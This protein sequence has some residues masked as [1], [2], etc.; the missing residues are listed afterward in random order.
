MEDQNKKIKVLVISDHIASLSGVALETRN[1]IDGLVKTGRYKF[2]CLG[3][4]IKH[5]QYNPQKFQEYGDDVVVYPVDGYGDQ[6]TYRTLLRME[7]PDIVWMI[8]DPRFYVHLW[9]MA[10]EIRPNLPIVY[11]HVWDNKPTPF[12][13][14]SYYDSNDV[15]CTISKLT[16]E[17]V[18]EV[19]PNVECHYVPHS[20]DVDVFKPQPESAVEQFKKSSLK[21]R[22]DKD[23][24]IVF[25]DNRNAR[26]KQ[27]G[28]LVFWFKEFLDKI[29]HDKA[30]LVMHTDVK[31]PNGQ[32]LEAIAEHLGLVN[33][34]VIFSQ[35]KLDNPTMAMMYNMADVT[36]SISDAEGFGRSVGGSLSCGTPVIVTKTGGMQDQASDG[37]TTF[38]FMIEPAARSIIGSQDVPYIYEDRVSKEDFLDCLTKMYNMPK[39]ER[40]RLGLLGREHVIKNFEL[41]RY[42]RQWDEI[43]TKTYETRGSWKTRK[44]YNRFSLVE[45]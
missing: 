38:G 15:I 18:R 30:M 33:G 35:A 20:F 34:E 1:M 40:K 6:G 43:L 37:E 29:G 8:T 14:K 27:S 21:E 42:V 7:K 26:R 11:Y 24:F 23:K 31:D 36:V 39:E 45:I 10:N 41:K 17:I 13:N 3:G 16:D 2:V 4:A 32:D 25:W 12:F 28:T 9:Q 5:P 19:A 22:Y 44:N